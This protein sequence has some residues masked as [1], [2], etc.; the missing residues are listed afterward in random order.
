MRPAKR[1]SAEVAG[2]ETIGF[3]RRREKRERAAA[4]LAGKPLLVGLDLAKKEHAVW[5]AG[6]DLVPIERFM[7]A[8]S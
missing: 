5:I 7:V 3:R 2:H 6:P 4:F 8:L 1:P